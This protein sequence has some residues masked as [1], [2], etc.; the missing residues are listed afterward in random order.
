[1]AVAGGHLEGRQARQVEPAEGCPR[2]Q[3][4]ALVF[5]RAEGGAAQPVQ[6]QREDLTVVVHHL[7]CR[8]RWHGGQC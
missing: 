4:V 5:D 8:G 7:Q 2:A 6:L 1:M 3:V